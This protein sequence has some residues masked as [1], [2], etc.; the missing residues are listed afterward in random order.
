MMSFK[1][2]LQSFLALTLGG[3]LPLATSAQIVKLTDTAAQNAKPPTAQQTE[4]IPR[5]GVDASSPLTLALF[6]AVKMALQNNREIEVERFNVQQS[7]YDLFSA[8]GAKDI[9]LSSAD[10]FE[11]RTIPVGSLLAG[12]A[13]GTMLEIIRARQNNV[14]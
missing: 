5:V 14:F 6:D 12:G 4:A 7:E 11:H 13:N 3:L 2:R 1:F 8:R 9:V 10:Y